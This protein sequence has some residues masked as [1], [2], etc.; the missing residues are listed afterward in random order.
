MNNGNFQITFNPITKGY[1]IQHSHW[2]RPEVLLFNVER[3]LNITTE[4]YKNKLREYG[5]QNFEVQTLSD[6]TPFFQLGFLKKEQAET[7]LNEFIIPIYLM[8]KLTE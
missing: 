3:A 4:E 6:Y 2:L 1:F 5:A 8:I 7:V